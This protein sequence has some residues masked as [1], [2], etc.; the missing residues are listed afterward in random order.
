MATEL[1][2]ERIPAC[3]DCI[4]YRSAG[5]CEAFPE[6]IP[7][8]IRAGLDHHTEPREGDHGV[9]FEPFDGPPTRTPLPSADELR[10]LGAYEK[11]LD[12]Q[13]SGR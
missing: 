3:A 9:T 13:A 6:A 1:I 2:V 5:R 4:H 10:A 7:D 8:D 12:R 11:R